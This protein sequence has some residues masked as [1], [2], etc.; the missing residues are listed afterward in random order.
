MVRQ[1]VRDPLDAH[2]P[3]GLLDLQ[4]RDT[5]YKG[6]ITHYEVGLGSCGWTNNDS[7][8]VVA[9]P[10]AMMNNPANPNDN[11]LCGKFITLA[12]AGKTHRAWIVDTCEGCDG[13]SLDLSPSLFAA[14]APSGNGR[15]Q[16]VDWW[17]S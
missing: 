14:V 15:V 16:S 4:Q 1:L 6:D 13:Q 12:Y 2:P 8:W 5:V 11:P 7:D 10:H 3:V 17:F 9:M